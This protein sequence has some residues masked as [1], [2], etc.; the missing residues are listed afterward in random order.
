M[1]DYGCLK[2]IRPDG[3]RFVRI[4]RSAAPMRSAHFLAP[5]THAVARYRRRRRRGEVGFDILTR[6]QTPHTSPGGPRR[7]A[8]RK[9]TGAGRGAQAV[10]RFG[11][12][13][14]GRGVGR[15]I[16]IDSKGRK[17]CSI[18]Q[19]SDQ[20]P[21]IRQ[22]PNRHRQTVIPDNRRSPTEPLTHL[23][24]ML[25]RFEVPFLDERKDPMVIPKQC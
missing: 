12:V 11:G 25:Q 15:D 5:Q 22:P 10:S 8:C 9:R 16:G 17:A 13:G 24:S 3:P 6:G 14:I 19:Q 21:N 18:W 1:F 23:S 2:E 20:I 7:R 4:R